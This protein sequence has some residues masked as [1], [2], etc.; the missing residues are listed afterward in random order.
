[1][2]ASAHLPHAIETWALEE[3]GGA[4][5]GDVRRTRRLVALAAAAAA[6]P[7]GRVTEV[8]HGDAAG[9]QA[10]YDWLEN[11]ATTHRAVA[12]AQ[13][14]AAARRGAAFPYVI[15]PVDGSDVVVTDLA[16]AKGTGATTDA[17]H[18][19]RGFEVV[20]ALALSPTGRALGL[21][22]QV[23]WSRTA[24]VQRDSRYR[25]LAE[26]ESRHVHHVIALAAAAFAV[27]A[28][29]THPW[30]QIDRGG[31]TADLL[32]AA[33]RD[34]RLLT[35]RGCYDRLVCDPVAHTLSALREAQS[36]LGDYTLAI[37]ARDGAPARTAR[38]AVQTAEVTLQL[39]TWLP[40]RKHAAQLWTVWVHEVDPPPGV[41]PLAWTLHTTYPVADFGDACLVVAAYMMRWQIEVFHRT[42]KSGGCQVE[43]T[44]LRSAE[45]IGKWSAILA[46]AAV[47]LMELR[48]L[49]RAEPA[50]PATRLFSEAEIEAVVLLR[51]PRDH[52]PGQV[53]TVGRVVRW[54]AE[55]GG[56][57]GKSSGG[58]PGITVL[59]RGMDRVEPVVT[60]LAN[61]RQIR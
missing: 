43:Q 33:L 6:H 52:V 45:A 46:S 5:F 19:T 55:L 9:R 3:F 56:Y 53:P 37:P 30:F 1:M 21:C 42:W 2:D 44:Q 20:S 48:D 57:T 24:R 29:T 18:T 14:F 28:P 51:Q 12:R 17:V 27:A 54:V 22:G 41:M 58:P 4:D 35:V 50:A 49:G 23:V 26:K 13:R 31:D 32:L 16:G 15:V 61:L 7:A 40:K 59:R 47:R 60:A 8:L 38:V 34:G 39:P 36:I 11:P 10:A 25:P